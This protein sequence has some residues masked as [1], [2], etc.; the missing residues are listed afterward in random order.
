MLIDADDLED[1]LIDFLQLTGKLLTP[2]EAMRKAILRSIDPCKNPGA[3]FEFEVRE[4]NPFYLSLE[5]PPPNADVDLVMCW[6][7]AQLDGLAA[8][9]ILD[10]DNSTTA[11][12][13]SAYRNVLG[14]LDFWSYRF[15]DKA[16]R[17]RFAIQLDERRAKLNELKLEAKYRLRFDIEEELKAL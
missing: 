3:R 7:I 10:R 4:D 1:D 17:E 16:W 15:P 6:K 13:V 11:E 12:I 2:E 14:W 9:K 5:V 8:S